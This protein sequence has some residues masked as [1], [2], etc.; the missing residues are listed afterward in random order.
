MIIDHIPFPSQIHQV[1]EGATIIAQVELCQTD[2]AQ[3]IVT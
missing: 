3:A 2:K 1:P